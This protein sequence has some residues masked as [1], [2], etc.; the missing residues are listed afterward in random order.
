MSDIP[1]TFELHTDD[2]RFERKIKLSFLKLF[3][4]SISNYLICER[5]PC[6]HDCFGLFNKIKKGSG[7]NF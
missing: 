5:I 2:M 7:I 6:M 3:D 1:M 4:N